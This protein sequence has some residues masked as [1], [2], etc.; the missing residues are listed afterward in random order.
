MDQGTFWRALT[1]QTLTVVV[2]F[3]VL[4]AL[5]IDRDFFRDFG[6]VVGPAAWIAASLVTALLVKLPLSRVALAAGAAGVAGLALGLAI[7]H[8]PGLLISLPLFAAVCALR[9]RGEEPAPAR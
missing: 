6:P 5:P 3:G 9:L 1:V 8:G 7:G 4:L 2:L